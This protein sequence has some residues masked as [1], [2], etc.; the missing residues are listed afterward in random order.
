MTISPE[1]EKSN[2][3]DRGEITQSSAAYHRLL[4]DILWGRLEADHR[5][6]LNELKEKYSI[7][8]SPLREALSRLAESGFVLREEN[9]GFRVCPMTSAELDELIRTRCW[10]EEIALRDSIRNGDK[11][12]ESRIILA[13]HWL[14]RS[15]RSEDGAGET[16]P[17]WEKLHSDFHAALISACSSKILI[18]YCEQLRYRTLRYRNL[19]VTAGHWE[20]K[21]RDEHNR[22]CEAVINKD[23]EAAVACL[24]EHFTAAQHILSASGALPTPNGADEPAADHQPL[25]RERR[26][27]E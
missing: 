21:E 24:R 10:L 12:W 25:K 16:T 11:D 4:D 22:L 15:S 3:A 13:F 19:A 2:R 7:G 6:R 9:R 23:E 5:L 26:C 20:Q 17:A 18:D 1:D 27:E 8:S 14:S